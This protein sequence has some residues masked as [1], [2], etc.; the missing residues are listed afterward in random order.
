MVLSAMKAPRTWRRAEDHGHGQDEQRPDDVELLLDRQRP[1]VLHRRRDDVLGLVVDGAGGEPPVHDVQRRRHDV[2]AERRTLREREPDPCHQHREGQHERTGG[3]QPTGP[4]CPEPP[5]LHPTRLVH[6]TEQEAGDQEPRQDEEDVD[7]D[8]AAAHPRQTGME[9]QHRADRDGPQALDVQPDVVP[10]SGPDQ[11][12]D[13]D[14]TMPDVA[15]RSAH[16][17]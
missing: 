8:V 1:E 16:L 5:Q 7:A 3:K 13:V 4:P 12:L 15:R 14:V 11:R 6:L 17:A 9:R 2:R 10:R